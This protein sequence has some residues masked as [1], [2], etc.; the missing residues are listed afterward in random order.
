MKDQSEF[1]AAGTV[2]IWIGNFPTDIELDDYMN[3]SRTFEESAL[4]WVSLSDFFKGPNPASVFR[5]HHL[6]PEI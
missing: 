2:S 5:S 1:D 4:F 6:T 3:L